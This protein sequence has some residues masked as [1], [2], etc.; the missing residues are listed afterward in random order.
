VKIALHV[1]TIADLLDQEIIIPAQM[2]AVKQALQ[3][4]VKITVHRAKTIVHLV[5]IIVHH[6]T[7]ISL[8]V[9]II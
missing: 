3:E 5:P 4:G 9:L 6:A 7:I 2:E 1:T 8:L